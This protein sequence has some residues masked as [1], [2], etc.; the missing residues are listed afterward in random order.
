MYTQETASSGYTYEYA[1]VTD[2]YDFDIYRSRESD[3]HRAETRGFHYNE[4]IVVSES[5]A[6]SALLRPDAESRGHLGLS[7][8]NSLKYEA[9]TSA[10]VQK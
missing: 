8:Q 4:T 10:R 3:D 9:S 2:S 7:I 1:Y 6:T 5:D